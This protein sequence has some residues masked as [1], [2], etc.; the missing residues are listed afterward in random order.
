LKGVVVS[1]K[2][3]RTVVVRRDY[4]RYVKKYRRYDEEYLHYF[5]LFFAVMR[6]VIKL[7]LFTFHLASV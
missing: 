5:I 4:L 7:C 1:T 2:M 6:N 3:K